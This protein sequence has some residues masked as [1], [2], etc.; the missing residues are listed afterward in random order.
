MDFKLSIKNDISKVEVIGI[1]VF[2]LERLHCR[3]HP[4]W[5]EKNVS[6]QGKCFTDRTVRNWVASSKNGGN[7]AEERRGGARNDEYERQRRISVIKE[8]FSQ[9]RHWSLRSLASHTSIPYGTVQRIVRGELGYKKI[10]SKWILHEL[11]DFQR[12]LRV[13]CCHSNLRML[14][15]TKTLL[16]RT[17]TID[18]SWVSLYM[19]PDRFQARQWVQKVKKLIVLYQQ[20]FMGPRGCWLCRWITTESLFTSCARS[21]LLWLVLFIKKFGR[22]FGQLV[23]SKK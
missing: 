11:T 8:C 13:V 4:W 6:D 20:I 21:R 7:V 12:Q 16:K 10:L 5:V 23:G 17:L 15:Q 3:T 22:A 1:V 2:I 14:S 19:E 18:E 9:S